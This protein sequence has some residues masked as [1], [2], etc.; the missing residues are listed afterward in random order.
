MSETGLIASHDATAIV[1]L[2]CRGAVLIG[3]GPDLGRPQAESGAPPAVLASG[4]PRRSTALGAPRGLY[5]GEPENCRRSLRPFLRNLAFFGLLLIVFKIYRIEER[6]YQG[7][8]AF[9]PWRRSLFWR[10]PYTT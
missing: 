4:P 3:M 10:C 7:R 6:A 1:S 9:R 5:R 2:N 8:A